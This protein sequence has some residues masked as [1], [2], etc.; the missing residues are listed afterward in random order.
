MLKLLGRDEGCLLLTGGRYSKMVDC[1]G[2]TV[3]KYSNSIYKIFTDP[4]G[5]REERWPNGT[6]YTKFLKSF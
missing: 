5:K 2:F 3:L 6:T 4:Q 1:T